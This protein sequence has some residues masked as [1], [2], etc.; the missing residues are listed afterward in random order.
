MQTKV[1]DPPTEKKTRRAEKIGQRNEVAEYYG[2]T[3]VRT[4]F[5]TKDI[6]SEARNLSAVKAK[7]DGS[8]ALTLCPEEK[9]AVLRLWSEEELKNM[10]LPLLIYYNGPIERA[11][12]KKRSVS[13]KHIGLEIVGTSKSIAEAILIKAAI[14]ILRES[15][16]EDMHVCLNSI[17]DKDS[18]L[19]FAR[20]LSAY[21]RKHLEH[22]HTPCRQAFKRDVFDLLECTNEKCSLIKENAPKSISFLSE[23]SRQ[24]FK[25]VLEYIEMLDIPYRI[26]NHLVGDKSFCCQTLFEIKTGL[27]DEKTETLAIGV[28]YDTLPKRL[29]FRREMPSAGVRLA[30]KEK[31]P[32][33]KNKSAKGKKPKIFFVQ[34]GFEAKLRSLGIMEELRRSSIPIYQSLS[35]DKLASQLALAESLQIPYTIIMGQK[36]ALEG[37][38]IVR[39]MI[40]RSQET[41]P[42]N[43]LPLYLKRIDL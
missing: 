11:D 6:L 43:S 4:P 9:I 2:F 34:L 33:L 15:G 41:I 12:V 16:Y 19:R 1:S 29:G 42:I 7:N 3:L 38:I 14:E 24:H 26:H 25:E 35:R 20:E 28:R 10:S 30:F 32:R 17:G 40:S 22:L 37:S 8:Y 18:V 36:E 21:Y 23:L 13:E 31:T 39:D 5:I 27:S